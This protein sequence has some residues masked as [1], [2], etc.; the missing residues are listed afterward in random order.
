MAMLDRLH[1]GFWMLAAAIVLGALADGLLREMPWGINVPLWFGAL[2]ALGGQSFFSHSAQGI[3]RID[4]AVCG[5]R[6]IKPLPLLTA[7]A[8]RSRPHFRPQRPIA[9]VHLEF[10]TRVAM[11]RPLGEK[12]PFAVERHGGDPV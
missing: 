11:V 9:S 4:G 1:R 3:A 6:R 5:R 12:E 2:S 7:G 10:A 8:G